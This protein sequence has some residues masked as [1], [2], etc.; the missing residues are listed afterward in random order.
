MLLDS[1][2][3]DNR[4]SEAN[5]L[6]GTD[7]LYVTSTADAF[8]VHWSSGRASVSKNCGRLCS[9]ICFPE[10]DEL[11][12]QPVDICLHRAPT[13]NDCGGSVLSYAA[14]WKEAGYDCL[15][16]DTASVTVQSYETAN[17]V[18]VTAKWTLRPVPCADDKGVRIPCHATYRFCATGTIDISFSA[19]PP[20]Y[21]PALPRVGLR[22]ALPST[23]NNVKWFGRG[24]HE[25]YDDRKASAYLGVFTSPVGAL[26]TPY[27]RPQE[28]GRRAD[29]RWICFAKDQGE[30]GGKLHIIP[31]QCEGYGFNASKFPLEDLATARH[32]EELVVDPAAVHVHV[33]SRSMG[34]GGYDS[35]SPNVDEEFLIK[36]A[37]E[38]IA[39]KVKMIF[40]P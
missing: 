10:G 33:D 6:K 35:W 14:R 27:M 32:Q 28:N 40:V 26:H 17:S 8:T 25:A 23:F 12:L 19:A 3:K 2:Q 20:S 13:D 18:T 7:D 24:P 1:L 11:L 22:A 36:P 30:G 34:V 29:P 5:T 31:E 16:R 9:W 4:S 37:G 15:E 39:V 21:L 38:D